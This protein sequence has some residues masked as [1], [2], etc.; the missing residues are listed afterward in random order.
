[1][2]DPLT[3]HIR[4][5]PD[6][7]A[8]SARAEQQRRW[9]AG[10]R[11]S[12]EDLLRDH[13]ALAADPQAAVDV[14][15]GE[16]FLRERLGE[17]PDEADYLRRFPAYAEILKDQFA[18]HLAMETLGDRPGCGANLMRTN[19]DHGGADVELPEAFGRY[20]IISKIGRGGMGAVY[21]AHD[22]QLDRR[23]A[24]KVPHFD[25]DPGGRAR[26]RFRREARIAATF[27]HPNLCPI[28]DV[29]EHDGVVYLTM[30]LLQGETLAARLD[31][32]TALPEA[33]AARIAAGIARAMVEA[34][35]VGVIHRDLKPAN[36]M[37]DRR[38]EPIVMDFGLARRDL[39][40]DDS[41]TPWGM[42]L[43][44]PTYMAPE[45]VGGDP[46]DLSSA[47]DVYA[48]GV[49]LYQ[50]LV[51]RP[52]YVGSLREVFQQA[53]EGKPERPSKVRPGITP[54]I[55]GVCLK[56][57]S[58]DPNDRYP[59]M[60]AFADAL[61]KGDPPA[62]PARRTRLLPIAAAL[63]LATLAFWFW[64]RFDPSASLE[65]GSTWVGA[66]VFRPPIVDYTGDVSLRVV[67]RTG[68]N[69]IG[70][71][72]TEGGNYVWECRGEVRGK[73]ISW[74]FTRVVREK[75]PTK[76]VGHSRVTGR[77]SG[78]VMSDLLFDSPGDGIADMTLTR[79]RKD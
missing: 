17:R 59:S 75:T 29:G 70:L 44:T 66:F 60:A 43:G 76:V 26:A 74:D 79:K 27:S 4:P 7:L 11:V 9:A 34:H 78:D 24:L 21:L 5:T 55:E 72:S 65:P 1:M 16:Y 22:S 2:H 41:A 19:P 51:G 69:F 13:P 67:D 68:A 77:I 32:E 56:A 3:T 35:A 58:C 37:L 12:A 20:R 54:A 49:I 53:R 14:I 23:V 10:D 63:V 50:M 46:N 45:Q 71:Y 31:R 47:C 64:P 6:D 62:K 28:F 42:M 73:L 52:P 40:A 48:L 36:V 18:L 39:A 8:A 33:E 30:P 61:E 15:Y 25:D 38:G 57:M